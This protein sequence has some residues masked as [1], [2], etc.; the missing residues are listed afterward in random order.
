MK[1]AIRIEL[2]QFLHFQDIVKVSLLCREMYRFV[3][4]NRAS[5]YT[6]QYLNVMYKVSNNCNNATLASRTSK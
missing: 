3:D 4:P 1:D 2:F 6:D 5:I